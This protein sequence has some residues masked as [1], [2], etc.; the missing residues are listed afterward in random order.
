ME[1]I[2]TKLGQK[3]EP[4]IRQHLTKV[5][6]CL[7][8]TALTATAGGV[9]YMQNILRVEIVGLIGFIFALYFCHDDKKNS[10]TRF[11]M[12]FVFG[13][14][15]G[16]AFGLTLE[17]VAYV[18]LRIMVVVALVGVLLIFL[19]QPFLTQLDNWRNFILLGGL[20]VVVFWSM[21][22]TSFLS[23]FFLSY[24]I[25]QGHLYIGLGVM[26]AFV[27][28]N[29]EDIIEEYRMGNKDCI[30][31]SLYLF[32]NSVNILTKV[33]FVLTQEVK[34]KRKRKHTN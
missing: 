1:K 8:V 12:L 9:L 24:M 25:E 30:K 34:C 27:L 10:K 6:A 22:I 5:Y 33:S 18:N 17:Y 15:F 31:H 3:F 19:P 28:N 20:V 14:C 32:F 7:G 2:I 4:E 11:M 21:V 26:S 16:Q 13:F 29:T 23:L